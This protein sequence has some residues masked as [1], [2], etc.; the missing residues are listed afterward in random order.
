MNIRSGEMGR[1]R[2]SNVSHG[3]VHQAENFL[4]LALGPIP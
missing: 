3:T 2:L 1:V 4:T